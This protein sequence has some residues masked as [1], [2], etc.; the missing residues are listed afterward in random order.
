V[1]GDEVTGKLAAIEY[2]LQQRATLCS[3]DCMLDNSLQEM[4]D[5]MDPLEERPPESDWLADRKSARG[6]VGSAERE[7]ISCDCESDNTTAFK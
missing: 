6:R 3:R 7:K 5:L 2:C 1:R 4:L